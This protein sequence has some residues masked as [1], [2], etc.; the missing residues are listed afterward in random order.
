MADLVSP[1]AIEATAERI[2]GH[3]LRTPLVPYSEPP[4]S[5]TRLLVKAENLQRIGAF[6]QR[7]AFAK[8]SSLND[9]ERRRGVVAHSSGNH[10]QAVAYAARELGVSATIV[11]P[12]NAP[13]NKVAAT[14]AQ[15]AKVVRCEPSGAARLAAAREI[16]E[17]TGAVLVPPYDD[18]YVIAGQGTVGREIAEDSP[19]A[20]VVLVPIS[21]GGLISGVA[22]AIKAELPR[23]LVVGVEPEL[24]AH[25]RDSLR[26]GHPVAWDPADTART[27]ADGLRVERLGD[28]TFA[29]IQKYV[30][31]IVTVSE[32][33]IRAAVR[34]LATGARLVAEPSG[35]VATAAYLFHL[36]EL[37]RG[38]TYVSVLSGGN[39][40]ADRY[41]ELLAG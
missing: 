38:R 29:H 30:D 9:N 10:A 41:A 23:A 3:V 40:S 7:G 39:V 14:E 8:V 17:T 36:D 19:D 26:A 13:P 18:P 11:I 37:P 31:A 22:T 5:A 28:L 12:D 6:K 32:D 2:S 27:M 25:A 16:A 1:A 24:A 20:D 33:E 21:G 15:G 34:E 4:E 35:A